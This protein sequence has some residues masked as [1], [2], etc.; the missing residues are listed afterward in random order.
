MNS[1]LQTAIGNFRAEFEKSLYEE[2][3]ESNGR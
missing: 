1:Q 3:E 2:E